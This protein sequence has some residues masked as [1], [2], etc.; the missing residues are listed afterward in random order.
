[1][2]TVLTAP[3][4]PFDP[5][6]V[7]PL[8]RVTNE[9]QPL[10]GVGD[11]DYYYVV[12]ASGPFFA[13]T[14][15]LRFKSIQGELRPLYEGIDYQLTHYFMGAS[16]A[17]GKPI[18]GSITLLNKQINGTLIFDAYQSLGGEWTVDSNRIATILAQL[19]V[20]PRAAS[21]DNVAGY[22]NI[23]PVIAHEWNLQD[24]VGQAQ[25]VQGID[26]IVDA[27]M[28]QA[29]SAMSQ[30]INTFSGNPHK[31]TCEDIDAVSRTEL[32]K[33][34][35]DAV[36]GVLVNTDSVSEGKTNK[37]FTSDRVRSTQ[38]S[39]YV[40]TQT[41]TALG[42]SDTTLTAFAKLQA[43]NVDQNK[44]LDM[45]ANAKR[46][47]FSG[48]GSQNLM[49][50]I[51][52]GTISIDITQAEA[53]QIAIG[54]S[55]SIAFNIEQLGDMSNKVIEF[56]V[57]TVNSA[58]GYAIAWPTNVKWVDGTPPPRSTTV[59]ARDYWYFVSEDGGVTWTGSLSNL[60]PH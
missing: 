48:L 1:M 18:Y 43:Q 14:Q 13:G 22:P 27:I 5:T 38:L 36:G 60:N 16:R 19:T 57:T 55:G 42:E 25:M 52:P 7:N 31:V 29:S 9:L 50:I 30:H 26:R 32:T 53:Y 21:W 33:V 54:G 44:T 15:Q 4:F 2:T 51:M 40:V 3:Q 11:R 12:P 17:T 59:G 49:K 39:G 28:T 10:T 34:V 20:D 47:A 8:N 41:T 24:L 56:S 58:D 23:F 37:Y 46:P 6:G 45:K 35:A